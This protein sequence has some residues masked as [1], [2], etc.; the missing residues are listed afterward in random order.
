MSLWA[1]VTL[2]FVTFDELLHCYLMHFILS[3][4]NVAC[5]VAIVVPINFVSQV[6]LFYNVNEIP[7]SF[8]MDA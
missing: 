4:F 7:L 8:A 5:I 2:L 1:S 3:I 6:H